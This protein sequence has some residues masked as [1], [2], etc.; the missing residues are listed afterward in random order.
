VRKK[1]LQSVTVKIVI[2]SHADAGKKL[3]AAV[4]ADKRNV[5]FSPPPLSSPL[6]GEEEVWT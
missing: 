1:G 6:K 5:N 3:K 4:A 2:A